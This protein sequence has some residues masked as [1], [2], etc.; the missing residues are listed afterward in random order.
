MVKSVEEKVEDYFK[1]QLSQ[2]NIKYFCKTE[3]INIAIDNAL[4]QAQSKSGGSGNNYP[5]IK[6]FLNGANNRAIPVMIEAKGGK[7]KLIKNDAHG[8]IE[9]S[10]SGSRTAITNFAVNGALHYANAILDE[11]TYQEV[12]AI[13][14]NGYEEND[15]LKTEIAVFYISEENSRFPIT[16]PFD[17][18]SFLKTKNFDKLCD[19][20]DHCTLTEAEKEELKKDKRI[21][22]EKK[23][24]QIHQDIYE[25]T[26]IKTK[27]STN[28]KLYLF[29]GLIMAALPIEGSSDLK[30]E[31]LKGNNN[32]ITHDG[33]IILDRIK[34]FLA[35]KSSP[36]D[37]SEMILGLLSPIFNNKLICM[38]INGLSKL[39]NFYNEIYED[40]IPILKLRLHVDFTGIILNSLSDWLKID[41]D[42]YNDVVL[43][44]RYVT[45]LM[46]KLD[47]T[48]KDSFV[49]D[50][51]MG[52]GGFLIAAMEQMV[53]DVK[54]KILTQE[55]REKKIKQIKTNQLL[56][57]EVLG[58]I[59]VLAVINMILTGDG[60]ANI[61]NGDSF[62]YHGN[63][64]AN[65]FLLNPPYSAEGK[66]FNFVERA[67]SKMTK[68]YACV[69]IQ[70]N[71]GSGNGLPYTKE[72]LQNNSLLASI[73]MADIFKGKASVQ[74][75]IY[76]FEVNKQHDK[77][78]LVTFIDFSNDGY[79]RQNRRKST[80]SVNLQD[81]DN[82]VLRYKEIE[83]IIL[84]KK[85]ETNYYNENN[86]L[87]I[88][89][90]ISLEGNDWTYNQ[91]KKIG[92][93]PT[94]EDFKTTIKD[95]L[96]WKVS[97]II[98]SE[99][100]LSLGKK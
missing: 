22:L 87:V 69:L 29:S 85:K 46:V 25:D 40:I 44:P 99:D 35:S 53:E 66:G 84:G 50:T 56:G 58:N 80:E 97:Q 5:D 60:S 59:F 23:I 2:N 39:R 17:D 48:N 47:R 61:I 95:F 98:Q 24:K 74:T 31:D 86:G 93:I 54:K 89:D 96:S 32:D 14:L 18:L 28:E 91:H 4:K 33:K 76:L 36:Q 52:S 100:S 64:P 41:N 8:K 70:E 67:L 71:A 20:L 38:P 78:S 65:V 27:L 88:R 1:N 43:T 73:H 63:F 13:G 68:G 55:E 12:I 37:K 79:L 94:E 92:I 77:D 90:T 82:A 19:D 81:V 83:A 75:A 6:V 21:Q 10:S 42:K 11:G 16:L 7:N 9:Y 30:V 26:E 51:A 15:I 62:H 72:I 57:I 45:S 34:V 49:W 3:T